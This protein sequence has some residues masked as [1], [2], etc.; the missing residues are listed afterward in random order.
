MY[1]LSYKEMLCSILYAYLESYIFSVK[2]YA[3]YIWRRGFPLKWYI[4]NSSLILRSKFYEGLH[5]A[6]RCKKIQF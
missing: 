4:Q 2:M 6:M 5:Y 3:V 1:V